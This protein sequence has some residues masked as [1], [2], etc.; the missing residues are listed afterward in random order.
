MFVAPE[1]QWHSRRMLLIGAMT[2]ALSSV[3][4][5]NGSSG[6]EPDP[7]DPAICH[8]PTW[9]NGTPQTIEDVTALINAL[10]EEHGGTVELPCFVASLNRPLGAAGSSGF[11]SA[12]PAGGPL[13][14]RMFLWSGA[15]VMSVVP[16]GIG[17]NLL[18]M[19]LQ[20]EPTHSIKAEIEFPVTAPLSPSAPYDRIVG[21]TGSTC[22]ACHVHEKPAASITWAKAYESEVLR[23]ADYDSVDL[24]S[25]ALETKRCDPAIEPQRCALLSAIFDQGNYH[26]QEFAREARTIYGD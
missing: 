23:I 25:V 10:A 24:S 19:G 6:A 12:Q 8:A 14:P 17:A 22:S 26:A 11:V 20:T 7:K 18:E 4:C 1:I 9:V 16:E 3:H 21:Q 13:S 15:L 5:G 2:A